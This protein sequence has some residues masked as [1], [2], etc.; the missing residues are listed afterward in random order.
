MKLRLFAL[1]ALLL[2]SSAFAQPKQAR[3]ALWKVSDPD[4]TIYLFGTIHALPGDIVWD[5]P[6]LQAAEAKADALMIETVMDDTD[7]AGIAAV[8][9][10]L[11]HAEELPPLVDRVSPAKRAALQRFIQRSGFPPAVLDSMRTWAAG[12]MLMGVVMQDLGV[13]AEKGVEQKL[14]ADF[15]ARNKP[16]TGLETLEQQLGF[17]NQISEAGQRD[18]LESVIDDP[19]EGRRE[20]DRMVRAWQKGDEKA[21]VKS[22]DTDLKGSPELRDILLRTRNRNWAELLDRRMAAPGTV[23]V[24]VGAGHLAGPESVV[25]LLKAKGLRVER[26]Q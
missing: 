24:A 6:V 18:F 11:G 15:R 13:Q 9:F 5:G 16:V 23:L 7:P 2:A 4:T 26:V 12:T 8:L 14:M 25:S 20:F 1:S 17:F 3:P 19:A 22:F 21:I 10:K